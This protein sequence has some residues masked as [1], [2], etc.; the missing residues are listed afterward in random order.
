MIKILISASLF[1]TSCTGQ[2]LLVPVVGE[3]SKGG[4]YVRTIPVFRN[5]GNMTNVKYA[6]QSPAASVQFSA[7]AID[8]ATTTAAMHAG[9]KGDIEAVGRTIVQPAIFGVAG[10]SILGGAVGAAS[11]ALR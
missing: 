1:L 3:N 10:A 2:T 8:N 6:L 7:D 4:K 9:I 5:S 11:G